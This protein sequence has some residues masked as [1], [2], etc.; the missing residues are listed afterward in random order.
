MRDYYKILG[1]RPDATQ[2][3]I[4]EAW[5]FSVKAFHPD[6]FAGSSQRQQTVAQERMKAIN[7]AYEV[8]SDPI[9]KP[10]YDRKYARESRTG[11]GAPPPPSPPPPSGAQ[12]PRYTASSDNRKHPT[13]P[14]KPS[15]NFRGIGTIP[16]F[17]A[18]LMRKL[19][20]TVG[21]AAISVAAVLIYWIS[22]QG[23]LSTEDRVQLVRL[24]KECVEHALRIFSEEKANMP[25]DMPS[26]PSCANHY[27]RRYNKCFVY[28]QWQPIGTQIISELQDAYDHKIYAMCYGVPLGI[29]C[30]VHP[31]GD[32]KNF[33]HPNSQ[34]EFDAFVSQY[35][36]D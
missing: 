10:S 34:E 20:V 18:R 5:N 33:H 11:A 22:K 28:V 25:K 32:S 19:A 7:E 21:I 31:D 17:S 36:N 4:K 26:V 13:A 35:M 2:A 24:D 14:R 3:E 6:K 29:N 8:L 16:A 23:E 9:R 1:I 12:R 15:F 30:W 27:S